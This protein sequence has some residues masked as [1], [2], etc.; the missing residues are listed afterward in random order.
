MAV[1][2]YPESFELDDITTKYQV[3]HENFDY[4][5]GFFAITKPHCAIITP[6]KGRLVYYM[7]DINANY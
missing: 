3:M 1:N 6:E 7:L 2:V 4:L 5:G